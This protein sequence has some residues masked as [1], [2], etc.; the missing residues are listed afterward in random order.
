MPLTV[1]I[2][3]IV[4][5][6][7]MEGE[8]TSALLDLDTGKVEFVSDYLRRQAERAED[9][10]EDPDLPDWQKP[11]WEIAKRLV[12]APNSFLRLPDRFDIHEW[13]IMEDF[14]R[15]FPSDAI[16]RQLMDAIHGSGAFRNFK[17]TIRRLRLEQAWDDFC[18]AALRQIAID[19][20]EENQIPYA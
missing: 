19:W 13:S 6:M 10:S 12:S 3:D 17:S 14:S 5:A 20:C 4:L 1:L 8:E 9:G 16:S 11:E 15:H 2:K 18:D 7:E